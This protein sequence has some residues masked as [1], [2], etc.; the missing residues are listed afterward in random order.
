MTAAV[1]RAKSQMKIILA[2]LIACAALA[3]TFADEYDTRY[4]Q[5]INLL[6]QQNQPQQAFDIFADLDRVEPERSWA[7]AFMCGYALRV[8]LKR[9]AD[10]IPYFQRS[11]LLVKGENEDPYKNTIQAQEDIKDS[12]AAIRESDFALRDLARYGK[13]PSP[14][15]A[16]NRAWLFM[17]LGRFDEA[18]KVAPA[19]SWVES[20][21]APR[22]IRVEWRLNFS[23]LMRE[24]NLANETS[25]RLSMPL[26][27][28]YQ[29][30]R[31]RE[32]DVP[33]NIGTKFTL[34]DGIRYLELTR[35]ETDTW[36]ETITLRLVVYQQPAR[37]NRNMRL[38][39]VQPGN[40]L[41]TY[42][43]DNGNGL[44]SLD[45]PEFVS[46]VESITSAGRNPTEKAILALQYL[47]ANFR[48]GEKPN[49]SRWNAHEALNFGSGD[50][51][52][53]SYISIAMLRALKIPVRGIYG[54]NQ[55]KDPAPALPHAIL[56]IYDAGSRQWLPHDPQSELH[57]GFINTNYMP[58]FAPNPTQSTTVRA[59]DG[60]LEIDTTYFFWTGSGADTMSYEIVP[61]GKGELNLAGRG[62]ARSAPAAA[63]PTFMPQV[64]IPQVSSGPLPGK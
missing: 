13:T 1:H 39:A 63:Q 4:A 51:G 3:P 40:K 61:M 31:K 49:L 30:I 27:R 60:I 59:A 33:P 54:L 14:W 42:A 17:Q 50:C 55:W 21:L 6:Y 38:A 20:Q 10:S 7:T 56:E 53:Y 47:R 26:E 18:L 32:A 44:F 16:E 23:R 19:G 22:E 9:P 29:Q 58:L 45:N 5:A 2:C 12:A 8:Y 62:G 46:K 37:G 25:I 64:T 24:W 35:A 36:P 48:Y 57:F 11:R 52:Y 34:R 41:Y 43:S 15:F 28:S